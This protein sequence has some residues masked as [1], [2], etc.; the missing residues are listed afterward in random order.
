MKLALISLS[1]GGHPPM[2]LVYIATYLKKFMDSI[3]IR[4]IDA[5]YDNLLETTKNFNPD[6]AGISSMTID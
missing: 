6:I 4:I 2:G 3:D 5:N 1:T